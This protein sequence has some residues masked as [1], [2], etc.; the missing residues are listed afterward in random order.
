MNRR[1]FTVSGTV[2]PLDGGGDSQSIVS[3]P[4]KAEAQGYYVFALPMTG[5]G[6]K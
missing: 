2:R 1:R 4:G 6:N 5:S 3:V